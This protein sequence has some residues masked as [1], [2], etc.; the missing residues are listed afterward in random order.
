MTVYGVTRETY[1]AVTRR[2]GSFDAFMHGLDLLLAAG[3]RVRLKAMAIKTNLHEYEA[4]AAFCQAKTKDYYRFDPQLHL[5]FDGDAARNLVIR[6]ERLSP[7]EIV[8]LEK[9]DEKRVERHE[10]ELRHLHRPA[11]MSHVGCDHLFHCGAGSGSFSVELRRTLP[12][13]LV[14]L[15]GRHH[16]RPPQGHRGRRLVQLRPS[17][18]RPAFPAQGVPRLLPPVRDREPLPLVPRPR[19]PGDGYARRHDAGLL[20]RGAP[21][22]GGAEKVLY[23]L[24]RLK[25]LRRA[26]GLVWES[27][28][29]WTVAGMALVL[30]QGLLPLLALWLTKLTVDAVAGAL[31]GPDPRA[32]FGRVALL[33][34]LTGLVALVGAGLRSLTEIVREQQAQRVTDHVMGVIHRQSA[35]LDL[36]YYEDPRYHDTLFRAQQEAPYRPVRIVQSLSAIV[37][38]G[39]SL[40]G[41]AGLLLFL[42]WGVALVLFAAVLP[43]VAVKLRHARRL[44]AWQESRTRT[45]RQTWAYHGMLTSALH[46]KEVRVFG[47]GQLF[48]ERY[49]ALRET[50]RAERMRLALGRTALDLVAQVAAIASLFGMLAFVAW[51]TLVGLLTLGDMV[52]Y[53]QAFQRAQAYLQEILGG[54]AGL[55][56]DTLFLSR[57]EEF[58]ALEARVTA[59]E[60]PAPVPR[61][62]RT[63]FTVEGVGFRYPGSDRPVLEDVRL[64]IG[65]GEVVAL[66]GDNGSGKTTLAKL[67][68]RLYDPDQGRITLDG[69]DLKLLDPAAFR[70]E[71]SAVFQDHVHYPLSARENVWLGDVA[72]DPDGPSIQRAAERAGAHP[73]LARLPKG[74]DTVLGNQFDDGVEL[75]VGEWQ[76]V[77]LARAFLRDAQLVI[78]DEPTSSMSAQAEAEVFEAIRGLLDGKAALLVSHRFSTVRMADRICVLEQGRIVE[79]GTHDELVRLGGRYAAMYELQ[80]RNYR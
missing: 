61:P 8:A 6:A 58:I 3:I 30:V 48:G 25:P 33:V 59:P 79:Q 54:M 14:P 7:D 20:R 66:V 41:L 67:L 15:G 11:D 70:R 52:M 57:F 26:V 75:S 1:E 43:G 53:Y 28:R 31:G 22:R 60:R 10:G 74:Y 34:S 21:A 32:A 63:G 38:S 64:T 44:H 35:A 80:A 5:R 49:R 23:E 46:A 69:V 4:I 68:C 76:K 45:E 18:P 17:R 51:R 42:H 78:L 24:G 65:P 36:A 73:L 2:P 37:Q 19:A 62:M 29:G 13:L 12:A 39:V 16:L 55:Y 9:A 47:L 40:L 72:T 27:A 50:L 77:A 56:E 71:V